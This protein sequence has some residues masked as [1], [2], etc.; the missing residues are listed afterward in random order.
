MK[1]PQRTLNFIIAEVLILIAI[2]MIA[3]PQ[4]GYRV[5][6]LMLCATMIIY[7]VRQLYFYFTMSRHM[8]G[9]KYMLYV[10]VVA[11][12]FGLFTFTLLSV[13]KVYVLAYLILT[14]VIT[15]V[16]SFL[17]A[18]EA[19]SYGAI[20]WR[21]K[22]IYAVINLIIAIISLIFIRY[23]EVLVTIYAASLIYAAIMRIY[24]TV[25]T[26]AIVYVQ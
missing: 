14:Y 5:M 20:S 1:R 22:M 13:P 15:A 12:D 10:G 23:S 19:K 3:A 16:V 8:V 4:Y 6:T 11:I 24:E 17:R 18:R 26:T 9:G 2:I 21:G 7:G 25:R